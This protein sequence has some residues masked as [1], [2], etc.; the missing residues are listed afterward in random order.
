V[1]ELE[2]IISVVVPEAAQRGFGLAQTFILL[3]DVMG[4]IATAAETD[5][6]MDEFMDTCLDQGDQMIAAMTEAEIAALTDRAVAAARS[7]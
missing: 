1:N 2:T 7:A 3:S 6:A 4:N 5:P